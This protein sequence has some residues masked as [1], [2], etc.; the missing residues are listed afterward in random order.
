[1]V[2]AR[3]LHQN[4]NMRCTSSSI[5]SINDST[6]YLSAQR[7]LNASPRKPNVFTPTSRS[8][9][10]LILDVWCLSVNASKFSSATPH[11]LSD[12]STNSD[13]CSFSR[14]S[15]DIVCV[16]VC[17]WGGGGGDS[18]IHREYQYGYCMHTR[19]DYSTHVK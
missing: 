9:K 2:T 18:T 6:T 4:T 19:S 11:P 8:E 7:E 5:S 14:T 12:I 15:E 17:V 3:S 16:C 1:M 10:S 13:P